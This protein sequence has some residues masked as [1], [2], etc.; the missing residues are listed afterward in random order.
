MLE[1]TQMH[2]LDDFV[3]NVVINEMDRKF[4]SLLHT[5]SMTY[6]PLIYR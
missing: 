3:G 6:I 4:E 2:R 1:D 5:S